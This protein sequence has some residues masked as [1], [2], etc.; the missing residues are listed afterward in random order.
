LLPP[1]PTR[2]LLEEHQKAL[3]TGNIRDHLASDFTQ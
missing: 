1:F 2:K 3:H